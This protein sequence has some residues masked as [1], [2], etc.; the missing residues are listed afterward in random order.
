MSS[1]LRDGKT[2]GFLKFH[3]QLAQVAQVAHDHAVQLFFQKNL[4]IYL[5]KI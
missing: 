1:R 4:C 5:L 3:A 2:Q